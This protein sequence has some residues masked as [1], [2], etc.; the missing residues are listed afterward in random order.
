MPGQVP[1]LTT[2][3]VGRL[4]LDRFQSILPADRYQTVM[5]AVKQARDL[6]AGRVVWNVNSTARGGGVAEL[7][8]SLLA[9]THGAG[10]NAR[11]EVISATEEFFG[12]TKR[13]KAKSHAAG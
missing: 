8:V 3:P 2:V 5:E 11:W 7:L 6:F 1:A 12:L 13:R 10:V 9:Y 4:S